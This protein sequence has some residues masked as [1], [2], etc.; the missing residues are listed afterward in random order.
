MHHFS[1]HAG[2][3]TES[4]A[5]LW[6]H[7]RA[8]NKLWDDLIPAARAHQAARSLQYKRSK[9]EGAGAASADSWSWEGSGWRSWDDTCF[10]LV[11]MEAAS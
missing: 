4:A 5:Q 7:R 10:G 6:E 11:D 3:E 2:A 8:R 1:V 9:Q